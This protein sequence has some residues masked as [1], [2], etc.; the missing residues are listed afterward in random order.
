MVCGISAIVQLLSALQLMLVILSH[1]LIVV[2][3]GGLFEA[4][5][6]VCENKAESHADQLVENIVAIVPSSLDPN[7]LVALKQLQLVEGR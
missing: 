1:L 7:T 4:E 5:S 3:I 2:N 6:E